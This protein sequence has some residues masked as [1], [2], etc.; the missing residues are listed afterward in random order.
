MIKTY[1]KKGLY[2]DRLR[3]KTTNENV[4]FYVTIE[5]IPVSWRIPKEE[6]KE[7]LR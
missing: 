4:Y 2:K 6:I 3:I 7:M 5:N 1:D